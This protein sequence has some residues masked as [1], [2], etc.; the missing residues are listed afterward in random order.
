MAAYCFLGGRLREP[1]I[2]LFIQKTYVG[3]IWAIHDIETQL[4]IDID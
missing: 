3:L 1:H 4:D 2:N